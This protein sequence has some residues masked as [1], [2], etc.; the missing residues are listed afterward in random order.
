MCPAVFALRLLPWSSQIYSRPPNL[1]DLQ[2]SIAELCS[3]RVGHCDDKVLRSWGASEVTDFVCDQ[4]WV[5]VKGC[6]RKLEEEYFR[7][8]LRWKCEERRM[9]VKTNKV[10]L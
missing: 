3:K 7:R 1:I 9:F 5:C 4:G 6:A 8:G 10:R 2:F